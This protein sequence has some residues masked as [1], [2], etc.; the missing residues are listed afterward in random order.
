MNSDLRRMISRE[1]ER[2]RI[3]AKRLSRERMQEVYA[4]EPAVREL[5][6]EISAQGFLL[7]K[8]V[9]G[10]MDLHAAH[11]IRA[12]Q[13][14]LVAEKN[15]LIER[16]GVTREYLE[17]VHRCRLCK[18]TGFVNNVSCVCFKSKLIEKF[19]SLS[20]VSKSIENENFA[21]FSFDHYATEDCGHGISQ[22]DNMRLIYSAA[23]EFAARFPNVPSNL[24]FHGET[25]LG[26][27][28]LCNCIAREVLDAGFLVLYVTAPQLFKKIEDKRF[29]GDEEFADTQID[30]V[31]EA[32]LLIID[33]LGSEFGTVVTK[34]ELFNILNSRILE[35]KPMLISTNLSYE[36]F[37]DTYS[38][39]IYS[40]VFGGFKLMK[41]FGDDIR[42]LKKFA[43]S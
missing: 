9:L 24:L 6:M 29:G 4:K 20:N 27:T 18:D 19:Y 13:K 31:Y 1:Y 25:G 5:E 12:R 22:Y 3:Q 2:D 11:G 36:D 33:D 39:R 17:D 10:E 21:T 37:R 16:A 42:A 41:F 7:A 40:R 26:K 8:I 14:S 30:L 32:D 34:S 38:D 15:R 43:N 35:H 23:K 28:F